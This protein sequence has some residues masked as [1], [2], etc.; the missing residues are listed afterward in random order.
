MHGRIY[1]TVVDVR[2][3]CIDFAASP[4]QGH[5]W[6]RDGCGAGYNIDPLRWSFTDPARIQQ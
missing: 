1:I 4:P 3:I 5:Q 2:L 6:F